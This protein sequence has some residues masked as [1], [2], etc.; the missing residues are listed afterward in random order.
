[1]AFTPARLI[2]PTVLTT[3]AADLYTAAS[4]SVLL[5]QIIVANKTASPATV[6][7]SLL[8]NGTSADSVHQLLAGIPVAG[9][10][11]L[12]L[13]AWQ[14]LAPGDKLNGLAGTSSALIVTASGVLL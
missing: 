4:R 10:D 7:L 13:D 2:N 6:T 11:I 5:K 8:P 14:V 9:N 1:M 12:I 3:S